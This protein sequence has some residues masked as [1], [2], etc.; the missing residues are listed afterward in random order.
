MSAEII[1]FPSRQR[2]NLDNVATSTQLAPKQEEEF[3]E[4]WPYEVD[5]VKV[6]PPETGFDYLELCKRFLEPEDY[7]DVLVAIM[8]RDAYEGLEKSLRNLVDNYNYYM[9]K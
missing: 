6:H 8:D 1:A 9:R 3:P 4:D 2:I 5:G 7:T